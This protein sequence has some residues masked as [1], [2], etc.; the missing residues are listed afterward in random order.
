MFLVFLQETVVESVAD[1]DIVN[2]LEEKIRPVIC[3]I[4]S[5]GFGVFKD[6]ITGAP[7]AF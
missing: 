3:P 2:K 7:K 4:L 6:A 1:S 5:K